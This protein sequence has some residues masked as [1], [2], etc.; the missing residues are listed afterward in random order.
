MRNTSACIAH[1]QADAY[2]HPPLQRSDSLEPRVQSTGFRRQ[3]NG[4]TNVMAFKKLKNDVSKIIKI[5]IGHVTNAPQ[6]KLMS[7]QF[8]SQAP[9]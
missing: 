2:I 8:V 7:Q 5:G 3:Q 9:Q 6:R 1:I 4:T